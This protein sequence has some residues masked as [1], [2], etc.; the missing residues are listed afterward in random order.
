M[1][2]PNRSTA[3][4]PL[5]VAAAVCGCLPTTRDDSA[6]GGGAAPGLAGS[7]AQA[8]AGAES[9]GVGSGM[10]GGNIVS[11]AG[12][13]SAAGG[14][15]GVAGQAGTSGAPGGAM[16]A[17]GSAGSSAGQSGAGTSAVCDEVRSEYFAELA[18]Q[19]DCNPS[20][21]QQCV[22]RAAAA[23]GCECRVFI[24]PTD[25][26]AIEQ[27]SNV[28]SGWFDA[29]CSMPSCPMRCSTAATGRCEV[30]ASAALGGRCVSP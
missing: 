20:A 23:P 25:P 26:F 24:Q 27:L 2:S 6:G 18:R 17:S 21:S 10:A 29:D 7:S 14:V 9:G 13:G 5:L 28:A 19:L 30:D 11:F 4:W 16:S 3:W 15:G 22:N 12:G 1:R 8:M